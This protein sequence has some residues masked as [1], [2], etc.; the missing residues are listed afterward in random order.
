MGSINNSNEWF[1]LEIN[2]RIK[3]IYSSYTIEQFWNWWS[4]NEPFYMEI[5]TIKWED[6]KEIGTKLKIPYSN[7]DVFVNNS[8]NL[9]RVIQY[10]R[11]N[12]KNVWFGIQ[13]RKKAT[14]KYGFK[15]LSGGDIFVKCIKYIFIDI[16]RKIKK[17]P[18]NNIELEVC[19]IIANKI[20]DKF[21]KHNWNKNY[22]KV[23][24]GNGVQL[25]IKLDIPIEMPDIEYNVVKV[26]N[27]KQYF[28]ILNNDFNNIKILTKRIGQQIKRYV[29]NLCRTKTEL[30]EK[31]NNILSENKEELENIDLDETSYRIAQVASLPFTKNFKYNGFLWRGIIEI[32]DTDSNIGLTD[33]LIYMN[34][35]TKKYS[36]NKN[37]IFVSKGRKLEKGYYIKNGE[38]EKNILCKFMLDNKFPEG[39]INNT[40]WFQLKCLLRDSNFDLSSEEFISFHNKIKMLHQRTFSLN[41]PEKKY[42]FSENTINNYCILHRLPIIYKLWPE[43]NKKT[44]YFN[45]ELKLDFKTR[46]MYSN[47]I[48]L[49]NNTDLFEDLKQ[50]KTY[51][52]DNEQQYNIELVYMF[53]NALEVKYG[54]ENAIYYTNNILEKYF[55]YD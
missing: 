47:N 46:K 9:K 55:L 22:C 40:L 52:K 48:K 30:I 28:P 12:E 5:R 6:A 14:N 20:L 2:D 1:N 36:S 3:N 19:D 29:N 32:K 11:K 15:C 27:K 38:L 49:D 25:F 34:E 4:D 44:L 17:G 43:K 18:A 37:N 10:T 21:S 39:G 33:H 53:I 45:N 13:P 42:S 23:C 31:Y 26:E 41:L 24:S 16:D 35:D 7:T 54:T 51:L 50:F 8:K